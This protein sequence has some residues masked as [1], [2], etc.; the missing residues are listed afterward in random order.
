MQRN[1]IYNDTVITWHIVIDTSPLS[2]TRVVLTGGVVVT[3]GRIMNNCHIT[4]VTGAL[5]LRERVDVIFWGGR[6][7]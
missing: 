5:Q 1:F 3:K 2:N 6:Q 4:L 7:L